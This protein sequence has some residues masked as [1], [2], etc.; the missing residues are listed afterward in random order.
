ME[1]QPP[2]FGFWNRRWRFMPTGR[3]ASVRVRRVDPLG[4]YALEPQRRRHET[5]I[6]QVGP[7]ASSAI[8]T[9]WRDRCAMVARRRRL[10]RAGAP[11]RRCQS[12]HRFRSS[13]TRP[14]RVH[15]NRARKTGRPFSSQASDERGGPR[16]RAEET[17]GFMKVVTDTE[18]ENIRDP[19]R[20]RRRSDPRDP[21]H[22]ERR[23]LQPAPLPIRHCNGCTDPSNGSKQDATFANALELLPRER[24]GHHR[25]FRG[26][27]P[28]GTSFI[29]DPTSTR[30]PVRCSS[31]YDLFGLGG[32]S[33][34]KPN[35]FVDKQ[36][37]VRL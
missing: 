10:H 16:G 7:S 37:S 13:R 6:D 21:R 27:R 14:C 31:T 5:V 17:K 8:S 30:L 4:H 35:G 25:G 3:H 9:S 24:L 20:Q 26:R 28:R 32:C 15:R 2:Q 34:T 33:W 12:R 1:R 29:F 36:W 18:T 19:G 23:P 11:R 22:Q